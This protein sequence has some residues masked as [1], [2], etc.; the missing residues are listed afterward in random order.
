MARQK[1]Y[2]APMERRKPRERQ[3]RGFLFRFLQGGL[4]LRL[5]AGVVSVEPFADKIGGQTSRN[6]NQKRYDILQRSAL[7][8]VPV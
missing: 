1:C 3:S 4:I 8:P 6:R 7:L 2:D 5:I